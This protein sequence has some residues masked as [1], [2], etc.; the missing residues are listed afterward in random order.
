MRTEHAGQSYAVLDVE[1]RHRSTWSCGCFSLWKVPSSEMSQSYELAVFGDTATLAQRVVDALGLTLA[2]RVLGVSETRGIRQWI[3][4]ERDVKGAATLTRL[5]TAAQIVAE[6]SEAL[7][8]REIQGWW[9]VAHPEFAFK[10]PLQLFEEG[11]VE[12][13]RAPLLEMAVDLAR[14]HAD[15]A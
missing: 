8:P 11:P 13:V 5:Q 1:L 7:T 12:T 15:E 2:A 6:L 4:G 14:R 9:T 10:S 3:E